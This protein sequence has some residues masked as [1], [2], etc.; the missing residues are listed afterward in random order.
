MARQGKA[1]PGARDSRHRLVH[2]PE[3]QRPLLVALF[4]P[5]LAEVGAS[6]RA[7]RVFLADGARPR[8]LD[9]AAQAVRSCMRLAVVVVGLVLGLVG[10]DVNFGCV[11]LQPRVSAACRRRWLRRRSPWA[12]SGLAEIIANLEHERTRGA[13]ITRVT[14]IAA[15]AR[16]LG[17]II[18]PISRG[19][20]L[21]SALGILPGGGAM[22]ASFASY[23][24]E[25]KLSKTP[26]EFGQGRHRRRGRPRGRQQCRRADIIHSDADAGHPGQSRDGAH[27][28]R[29]DDPGHSARSTI[30]TEQAD[31]VLGRGGFDVDRQ[32]VSA[33]PQ[34]AADRSLGAHDFGA[35]PSALPGH[36]GL[37]RHRRYSRS[38]T[39]RSMCT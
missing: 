17:K 31:A 4:A 2:S 27:D 35:I 13:A 20:V 3:R 11:T 18:G 33:D 6:V 30:I 16:R 5:P 32:R 28:R 23:S 8:R 21:G 14:G 22:L 7:G 34:P 26:E 37:L 9:R 38:A 15:V 25:K 12:C 29:A 24:L 19:T 10:T 39:P 36:H 1:G